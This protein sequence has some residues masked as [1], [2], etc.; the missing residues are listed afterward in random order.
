M[1]YRP[2]PEQVAPGTDTI[3]R[4]ARRHR[5]ATRE[6]QENRRPKDPS[7]LRYHEPMLFSTATIPA[8]GSLDPIRSLPPPRLPPPPPPPQKK[9]KIQ[10]W[11]LPTLPCSNS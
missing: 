4:K 9:T 1:I 2:C 8:T 10:D 3:A 11:G 5:K 6:E 7:P